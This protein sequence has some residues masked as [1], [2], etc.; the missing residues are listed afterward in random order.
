MAQSAIRRWN[1]AFMLIGVLPAFF[2]VFNAVFS[3]A[4]SAAEIG[5]VIGLIVVAYSLL[6]AAA[7]YVTGIWQSGLW[8]IAPALVIM[9]PYT[10]RE[11]GRL[12]LHATVIAA[13]VGPACLGAYFGQRLR[14]G[15]K[16]DH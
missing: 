9:I 12:M 4:G 15:R 14:Q 13:T 5:L 16:A 1:A 11:S 7:G 10:F 2:L 6:G 3:D 8:L